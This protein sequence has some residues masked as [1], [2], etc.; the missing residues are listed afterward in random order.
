MPGRAG[1]VRVAP[2]PGRPGR[3]I[4][5]VLPPTR[6]EGGDV[7][8]AG[9]QNAQIELAETWWTGG[10]SLSE[11]GTA[12]AGPAEQDSAVTR[13]RLEQW[14]E[15]H[16][17]RESGQFDRRLASAGLTPA[18]L[19]D[20]L[21]EEPEALAA[22]S[23]RPAW[24]DQVAGALLA[25]EADV[26]GDGMAAV[27]APFG[28]TA[29][30]R[31][32][33]QLA[34][35]RPA[36]ETGTLLT[37]W[38]ERL[39]RNLV[40]LAS[41]TLVLE[42]NVLRVSGRLEG[43][44]P[45]ERF[46]DFVR[47]FRRP[48]ALA[49]LCQEYPV[50][51]RLLAQEAER[52]AD[53]QVEMLR[54]LA[55]DRDAI[56][57]ELL[58]GAD[59]GALTGVSLGGDSHQGGRSVAVLTFADGAKVVYKP[60]PLGVHRHFNDVLTWL[61][62]QVAGLDLVRLKVLDRDGY[63]WVEFARHLPCPDAEAVDGYYHRLGALLAVLYALDGADFHCENLIACAD[64]PVLVDL[65]ALLHPAVPQSHAE[66]R[67]DP[68][69]TAAEASVSRSAL[70]PL[71]MVGENGVIDM[72]GLG[73]DKDALI[74]IKA[75]TWADAGTDVMRLVR[76]HPL[77]AGRQNRPHLVDGGVIPEPADHL[78]AMLSGFARAY[79][80]IAAHG[81]EVAALMR[82][83][84]EDEVRV[85]LR[86]T[87]TYASLLN[88]A[89]HP[90]VLRHGLDRDRL[91][92]Y[93]WA[94][95]RG[96]DVKERLIPH[97]IE[98]LWDNDVP[99]FMTRPGS[100]TLWSSRGA[101]I[102]GV[103]SEPSLERA[104]RKVRAMGGP[105]RERQEWIIRASM[106]SRDMTGLTAFV[107]GAA[108]ESE[109]QG[110]PVPG[111][112]VAA[113]EE[114]ADL[115]GERAY[116]DAGRANWLGLE[117]LNDRY[118]AP[119]P[120]RAELYGGYVGVA[121]FLARLAVVTGRDRYAD[122]ARRAVA[123]MPR[124]VETAADRPLMGAHNGLAGAVYGMVHLAAL[125][126]DPALA[127]PVET[128]ADLCAGAAEQDETLDIIGGSA[129]TLAVM[130]AIHRATGS[131]A[132]RRA[133]DA[134]AERLLATAT[135][136]PTG[137]AWPSSMAATQPLAGFSHGAG[138]IGW[139]LLRHA[140]AGGGRRSRET[141]LSAFA[142]EHALYQPDRRT[143]PDYREG[144]DTG[145]S[146]HAW[147]H[148]A[149]G[150]GLSRVATPDD[151]DLDLALRAELAHGPMANHSLCHGELGNLELLLHLR[152]RPEA[153]EALAARG[154]RL[155][156]D[157]RRHG[158]RCGAPGDTGTPGLMNGLAG[159]GYGLLRLAYPERTPSVLLLDAPSAE[160][161]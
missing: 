150:I 44:T 68:A 61:N 145:G 9:A 95:S 136:M 102:E 73:G 160:G 75:P 104:L 148:G 138:G 3:L 143:W 77:F 125:L 97:E 37:G 140:E 49:T 106:I 91:L 12:P 17:L 78:P 34:S 135:P 32:G 139:A 122:L 31:V 144:V 90:D 13:W 21:E 39:H 74:P 132:A 28:R 120:L 7:T 23:A 137:T 70:L 130:L 100:T 20:L 92:D 152:E 94:I 118:W 133:A 11:R 19:R 119:Q 156:R 59:P 27:V 126:E 93:L 51:A 116:L 82:T 53:G 58:A 81:E 154:G 35:L 57:A 96:D 107:G 65:E 86:A 76:D 25:P 22:R 54:R 108:P 30:S 56:V 87:Q 88:E 146:L 1:T 41:R 117:M 131:S 155:L 85:V 98:D 46:A 71:L 114:I 45:Q 67:D 55:D 109:P 153:A 101:P 83:F 62:G 38:T 141:A 66:L 24:A 112:L 157:L 161:A 72:S 60:R 43:D 84:A 79:D 121:L 123:A 36:G 14:G 110:A 111:E 26:G 147:C 40:D 127:D 16:G 42:L 8:P 33:A 159:I 64:Q 115:I 80:A 103:L 129:G 158:P 29:L 47:R 89:T 142:Y 15:R 63:G 48:E 50:L 128:V 52:F 134:A 105:D 2:L 124:V 113:A 6:N 4:G 10:L 69:L 151:P 149:P 99:I 5:M 18:R